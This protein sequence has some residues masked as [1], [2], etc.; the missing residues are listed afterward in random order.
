MENVNFYI[1]ITARLL[2]YSLVIAFS[3][4]F[5]IPV[6]LLSFA[7]LANVSLI[8]KTGKSIP[9]LLMFLFFLT[10]VINL[11]PFFFNGNYIFAYPYTKGFYE[12]LQIHALFLFSIDVFLLPIKKSLFVGEKIPYRT[13]LK[14]FLFVAFLF[15]FFIVF[16][17]RGETILD[18]GG[19]G[20]QGDKTSLGG[21]G[22]YFLLLIPLLYIY[23]GKRVLLRKVTFILMLLMGIK[24]LLYGG[25]IGVLMMGLLVFML[26]YNTK[27]RNISTLKLL[28]FSLP[29]LYLFVLLGAIRANIFLV[30]E[31][32]WSE[33]ALL[34]FKTNFL[35]T[36]IQFFGNQN[37]IFYSSTILNQAAISGTIG[38]GTRLEMFFYN[39]LSLVVPYSFLPEKA[40]VIP[41][42]QANIASTGGGALVSSYF[43]FFLS[44]PGVILSGVF[45]SFIINN[46]QRTKNLLFVL[47]A[48]IVLSTYPR[49][50]GYNM[51]SLFKISFYVIPVYLVVKFVF[52]RIKIKIPNK[53]PNK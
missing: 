28:L 40:A 38:M 14:G 23:G 26:Y 9:I 18:T 39:V 3:F 33:I 44:Y 50:F 51:I 24:L 6:L 10:Y 15:L 36:Y 29:I 13:N 19:Y 37:D 42:I 47:Y 5:H 22:E 46:L 49:W 43:Y 31:S 53:S 41:Y 27:S 21:F 17:I 45:I 25:R 12:T 48:V 20:R 1:N 4:F 30:L 34:P 35:D 7:I 8:V 16:A 11:I 52:E 2:I 32:S